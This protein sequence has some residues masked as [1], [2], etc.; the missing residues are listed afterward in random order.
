LQFLAVLPRTNDQI[1]YAGNVDELRIVQGVQ[2]LSPLSEEEL[3]IPLVA[4]FR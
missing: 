3:T 2:V 4:M 1:V